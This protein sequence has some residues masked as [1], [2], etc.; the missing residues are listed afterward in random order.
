[1]ISFNNQ[2]PWNFAT[3]KP[4][5]TIALEFIPVAAH[6]LAHALGVGSAPSWNRL[7]IYGS[8]RGAAAMEAHRAAVP[9]FDSHHW[10]TDVRSTS[11]SMFGIPASI[12]TIPI[13]NPLSPS[14]DAEK[15]R[16]FSELDLG[17]MKD[18]G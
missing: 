1:M 8:F 14:P 3:D 11:I 18:V 17:A 2:R 9:M 10:A 5:D 13:M 6:E 12:E 4:D 15:F 16:G 7:I